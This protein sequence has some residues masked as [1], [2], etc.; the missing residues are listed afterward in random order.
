MDPLTPLF[1]H[2]SPTGQ[3][4]HGGN[5]CEFSDFDQADGDC[6]LHLIRQGRLV[7]KHGAA[8]PDVLDG[9]AVLLFPRPATHQLRPDPNG[10]ADLVCARINLGGQKN[11]MVRALPDHLIIQGNDTSDFISILELIF[12][13]AFAQNSGRQP[14]LNR[15]VDYFLIVILRYVIAEKMVEHGLVAA[16]GNPK[17]A[18]AIYAI[19]QF[20]ERDWTLEILADTAGMSRSRFAHHFRE[21]VGTTPLGYLTEWRM[22]VAQRLLLR[23]QSVNSVA[24]TIGYQS[25]AALAKAFTKNVGK[26][27]TA[28]LKEE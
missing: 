3:V 7:I 1:T 13:E 27:P 12:S 6:H 21:T 19:H 15:L 22:S 8:E 11:P 10:G 9:P 4:F 16:M 5:L 26:S 20:P 2:F 18:K 17:L 25:G 28:W 14:A 24:V 23:G